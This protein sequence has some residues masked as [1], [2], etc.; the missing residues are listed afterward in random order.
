MHDR[1]PGR[2]WWHVAGALDLVTLETIGALAGN[3]R[4]RHLSCR[5]LAATNAAALIIT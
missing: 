5:K 2:S 3:L 1:P 4:A